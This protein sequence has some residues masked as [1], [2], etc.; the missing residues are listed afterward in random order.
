MKEEG[1]WKGRDTISAMTRNRRKGKV[2]SERIRK[3]FVANVQDCC[4]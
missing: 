3:Y 4:N 1:G 2:E